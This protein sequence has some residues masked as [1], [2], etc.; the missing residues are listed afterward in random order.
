MNAVLIL[1]FNADASI[2]FEFADSN[3][4]RVYRLLP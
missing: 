1:V 2:P 3:S 4:R